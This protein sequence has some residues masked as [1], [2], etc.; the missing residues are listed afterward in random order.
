MKRILQALAFL[1]IFQSCMQRDNSEENG[2]QPKDNIPTSSAP[3]TGWIS[4][5]WEFDPLKD[6]PVKRRSLPDDSLNSQILRNLL[7]LQFQDKI[8]IDILKLSNDTLF[9]KIDDASYLTQQSGTTGANAFL[10]TSTYTLTEIDSVN[11]INFSFKEG[12]HAAPGT[13]TR[14][15]FNKRKIR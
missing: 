15:Y 7:N 12:D 10:A 3:E 4:P 13:Y 1:L 5:L 2:E 6:N 14:E 9:I 11:Y 8:E